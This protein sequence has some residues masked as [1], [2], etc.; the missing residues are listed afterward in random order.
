MRYFSAHATWLPDPYRRHRAYVAA[1]R[2]TGVECVMG[3]F[4]EKDR[5]CKACGATWV[6]HEE[7]ETDVNIGLYMLDAAYQNEYD[8][9]LLI[10]AD[11]D[12]VPV[13]RLIR[14]RFPRK[15][16]RVI[17]PPGRRQSKELVSALAPR[18]HLD[19]IKRS[20]LVKCRLPEKVVDASGAVRATCP[21]EYSRPMP[22]RP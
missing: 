6:A 10:S 5:G 9:A 16:L 22:R 14:D 15:G 8:R 2:A 19:Q 13:L 1:L 18:P 12:L 21:V 3:Y 17:A 11:S 7:K 4:K 20:D